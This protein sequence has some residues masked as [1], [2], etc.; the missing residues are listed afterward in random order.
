[1]EISASNKLKEFLGK[2][3]TTYSERKKK[4]IEITRNLLLENNNINSWL[5]YFNKHKKK[6]DLADCFLQ[7]N[8]IYPNK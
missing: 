8:G 3:K 7:A 5:E 2:Q 4:S 1:M 6:D